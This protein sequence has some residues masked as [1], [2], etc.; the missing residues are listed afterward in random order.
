MILICLETE[1]IP[2]LEVFLLHIIELNAFLWKCLES[3]SWKAG[4]HKN[5]H[6]RAKANNMF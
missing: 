4:S 6:G 1:N 3:S 2:L 5:V